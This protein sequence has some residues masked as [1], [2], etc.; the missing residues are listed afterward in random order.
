MRRS[1]RYI[2]LLLIVPLVVACNISRYIPEDSYLVSKVNIV[3]DKSVP[4]SERITTENNDLLKLVRQTPNGRVLGSMQI[5]LYHHINPDKDNWWNEFKRRNSEEPVLLNMNLTA[6]SVENLE[7]FMQWKGYF[8]SSVEVEV[9]TTRRKHRAEVTYRITQNKPTLIESFDYDIRDASL[10]QIILADSVN[11]PIRPGDIF[12][13]ERLNAERNRITSML[14]NMGYFDFTIKNVS[15]DADTTGLHD[16]A[17]ICMVVTPHSISS[18][19]RNSQPTYEDHSIYRIK[20]INIY[21]TYDP[22]LRSTLGFSDDAQIDTVSYGGLRIIRD[23][24][25][26][27]RL[28]NKVLYRVL[29]LQPNTTYDAALVR[30]T[31]DRLKSLGIFSNTRIDFDLAP[32]PESLITFVG[33]N[34]KDDTQFVDIYERYLNCNIYCTPALQR[35]FKADAEV[36]SSADYSGLSFTLGYTDNNVFHGAEAFDISGRVGWE[37]MHAKTSAN[38][39]AYEANITAGL[40]FPR[41]LLPFSISERESITQQRTRLE[42]AFDFQNRPYYMRN[43]TTLRWA[44][45]WRYGVRST[46]VLRPIDVNWIDVRKVEEN[47]I[48]DINNQ[49]LKN[50]FLSQIN[51]GLTASYVYNTQR[52]NLDPTSTIVRANFEAS[53]NLIQG[54]MTM[55]AH[56]APNEDFYKIF[57]IRYSQY[58]RGE[59][60]ASHTQNFGNSVALAGRIF[61]GAG[62]AYGNSKNISIPFDRMFYCGG[63]SSMRGWSPR[64]LGPGSQTTLDINGNPLGYDGR[65]NRYPAQVG[66]MR[67]EANLELRFPIWSVIKGAVFFD[68]GN[69]WYLRSSE[70]SDPSQVFHI[71]DFYKQLGFNTGIGLRLDLDYVVIRGDLGL[72]LHNPNMPVGY[73]WIRQLRM[74]SM[75]LSFGV[76][77]PF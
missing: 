71:N 3:S 40:S 73:R 58:V 75:A 7:T 45:S 69:V 59:I 55:F 20:N 41:F 66:D 16:K 67:L 34:P 14:N 15:Y 68:V 32:V 53:G 23:K 54:L 17:R 38:R 35:S 28:R 63:A 42:L 49:Y 11:C 21:P 50:S 46:F 30:T 5:W 72:K 13:A 27:S 24:N 56:R 44:Y 60:N 77:Y 4:R 33:D 36:S 61:M 31:Y 37:F 8:E 48:T 12:D 25:H 1:V 57:G 19:D 43:I 29:P 76:G 74:N 47:F 70:A 18:G 64:T 22:M 2:F 52:D 6:R 62:L 26:S 10:R 51:A 9:D 65:D 39:N